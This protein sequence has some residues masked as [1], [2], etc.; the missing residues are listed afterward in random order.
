MIE[1]VRF[2]DLPD[3]L[4]IKDLKIYLRIGY[5]TAYKLARRTDFPKVRLG[6]KLVFSKVAVRE[7]AE[8]QI[9][10]GRLPRKLR[11]V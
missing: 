11:A 7:W 1:S 5:G 4:T 2:D 10:M 8:Q 6:N 9:K 3:F